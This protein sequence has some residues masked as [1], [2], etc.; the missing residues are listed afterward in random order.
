LSALPTTP[1]RAQS[2]WLNQLRRVAPR[3]FAV[4]IALPLLAGALLPVQAWMLADALESA[5]VRGANLS[6]LLPVFLAIAVVMAVRIGLNAMSELFGNRLGETIKLRLREALFAGLLRRDVQMQQQRSS[7]A[8]TAALMEQVD[9]LESYFTRYMPAMAQASLLPIAFGIAILP[10]DWVSALLFLFTAPLIPVFMAL[11]GWGAQAAT[12]SQASAMARLA[13][14]FSDRLRGMVTLKLYG[15]AEAETAAIVDAS[16]DLRRRT[17]TVLRI[18]FL[19]SAVLEFFAA[20]GVAGIALYV[21]LSFLGLVNLRMSPL[22]LQAG[23]FLLLMAPEVYQPLRLLA[24]HYHDRAAAK[25][26]A[27][28]IEKQFGELPVLGEAAALEESAVVVKPGAGVL[29][30]SGLTLHTPDR[31]RVLIEAVD[32][33]VM[34]GQPVAIM[35][36]SGSG[37]STLIE[38]LG[39]LRPSDG[40]I[41]LDGQPLETIAEAELRVRVA[42]MPQQPYVFAASIAGNIRL[43]NPTA[44]DEAV[45]RAA[46]MACVSDFADALPEGLQTRIGEAGLGLSGGEIHRVALARIFLRTPDVILLDEPTA[47]LDAETEQK[48]LDNILEFSADRSLVIV[49]HSAAVAGRMGKLFRLKGTS[50]L[51]SAAFVHSISNAKLKGVA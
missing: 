16:E 49:T 33:S 36:E 4:A 11:V 26:A 23:L 2:R 29:S 25:A 28:E 8:V 39:R 40:S 34:P 14:R 47:H 5:I 22:S 50:M 3:A 30:V 20:L 37:K 44:T 46:E 32:L 42:I 7:G 43:G 1:E 12:Q 18:A 13:G 38:A 17:K 10:L 45:R 41:V 19:S 6:V 24:A 9:A 21:G 27:A 31:T 51:P 35:G 48:V 15:R